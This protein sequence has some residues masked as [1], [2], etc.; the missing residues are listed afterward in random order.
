M[1]KCD[2]SNSDF[3]MTDVE[4]TLKLT[5]PDMEMSNKNMKSDH[6]T[7]DNKI[8]T[9]KLRAM[10]IDQKMSSTNEMLEEERK[11]ESEN[12]RDM[13]NETIESVNSFNYYYLDNPFLA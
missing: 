13:E 12:D 4:K 9:S 7:K 1:E 6:E 11:I 3:V 5:D 8:T 2:E 10:E